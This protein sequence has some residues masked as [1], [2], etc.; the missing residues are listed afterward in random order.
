MNITG[1]NINRVTDDISKKGQVAV[2]SVTF[3]YNFRVNDIKLLNGDGG[4][5][6]LFPSDSY[7]M[8]LA[9]PIKDDFRVEILNKIVDSLE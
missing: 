7:N 1:V 8:G 6:L 2:C 3:D 9:F 4:F 5:Y